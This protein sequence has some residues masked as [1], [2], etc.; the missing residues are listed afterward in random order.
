MIRMKYSN[1][2]KIDESHFQIGCEVLK[3]RLKPLKAS[4]P[5]WT[6]EELVSRQCCMS[7]VAHQLKVINV[8]VDGDK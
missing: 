7:V 2:G 3:E 1:V 5:E 4:N 8:N 6:W